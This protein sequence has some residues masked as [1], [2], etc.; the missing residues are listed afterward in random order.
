MGL[1][2]HLIGSQIW[3]DTAPVIYFV[4]KHH[5]YLRVI[6]PVFEAIGTGDIEAMTSTIT[7][8]EVLVHPFRMNN[9]PLAVKYREILLDSDHF[10]TFGISHD[11]SEHA[12]KL[13]AKYA[14]KT[15]DALQ[16]AGAVL[17]GA[18]QFVTNDAD[19]KKIT[20]IEIL[21]INDFITP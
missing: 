20:A 2:Q 16:I 6:R 3:V 10:T 12:A 1:V 21:V 14:I 8:L 18:T 5:T 17:H 7:L 9:T 15:P 11:I 13:R 4:E 19:L